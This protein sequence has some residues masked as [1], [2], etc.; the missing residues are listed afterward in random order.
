MSINRRRLLQFATGFTLASGFTSINPRHSLSLE[1]PKTNIEIRVWTAKGQ[2][3]DVKSLDQLYFLTL[4]DEPISELPRKVESGVLLS[5]CPDFPFIIALSLPVI[6]FGEVV[7]YADNNGKGYT[8]ADFP[9]NLN[10]AFAE[11]RLHRV[12]TYIAQQ[13]QQ[14]I[15]FPD[16]ILARLQRG[17]QYLNYGRNSNSILSQVG[18]F[19]LSLVETLWGGEIAVF[20]QAKQK[21]AQQPSRPYF[22]FG[23]NFFGYD[24]DNPKYTELFSQ[25]FN[26]A[27]IPFYWKYFEPERGQKAFKKSD[28]SIDWLHSHNITPKGHPL[29]YFHQAGIPNWLKDQPYSEVKQEIYNHILET[30]AYYQDRIPYYDIINEANNIPWANELKYNREQFLELTQIAATASAKGYPQVKRII[31]HCCA[32]GE[33]V[34]YGKPPQDSPYQYLKKCISA[35]IPFE[36]IGLQVYYPHQDMFEINRLLERYSNLGKPIHITELGVSSAAII[37]ES[38]Q[39]KEPRGLWHKPWS[40]TIQAD[41]I[42]QFYTICY[43]KPYIKAISWW[44]FADKGNF[45]A[46]GGLLD[47]N[48]QPKQSFYRLSRLIR[49]FR[50]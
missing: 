20:T 26:F 19:N 31:N 38:S 29:I 47:S 34:A 6:G 43:S 22:L 12:K 32:W 40:E 46:H 25:L 35:D 11:S 49:S 30:T 44:D 48:M 9:L 2:P 16:S 33:N 28:R 8:A 41:W 1:V 37:D 24:A 13:R 5:Q 21:I 39:L 14:G 7:L 23:S 17:Q 3:L 42:E 10:L 36:I 18:W 27:T 50:D 15:D 4:E 45:W